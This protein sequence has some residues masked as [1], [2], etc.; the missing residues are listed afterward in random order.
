M[1]ATI[2]HQHVIAAMWEATEMLP[3]SLQELSSATSPEMKADSMF[4]ANFQGQMG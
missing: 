3:S 4:I 1:G 2:C